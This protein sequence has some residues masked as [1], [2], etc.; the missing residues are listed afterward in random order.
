MLSAQRERVRDRML[1]TALSSGWGWA[2]FKDLLDS[3]IYVKDHVSHSGWKSGAKSFETTSQCYI[4]S[5]LV[6]TDGLL[7]KE[8]EQ[9]NLR[10]VYHM[11]L[12]LSHCSAGTSLHQLGILAN[13]LNS[14]SEQLLV[15]ASRKQT[16]QTDREMKSFL[17]TP[18]RKRKKRESRAKWW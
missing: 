8:E 15:G 9:K 1:N 13:I 18:K 10:K 11:G 4:F 3:F 2:R 7:W 6:S 17:M 14:K 16:L 5:F 12:H